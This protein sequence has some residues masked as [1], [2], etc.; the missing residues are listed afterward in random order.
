MKAINKSLTMLII[1]SIFFAI[2]IQS[3]SADMPVTIQAK[4]GE[5]IIS[6][7]A[8][9]TIYVDHVK[10]ISNVLTLTTGV[11]IIDI[12]W[13][14][15]GYDPS[16]LP[17]SRWVSASTTLQVETDNTITYVSG[18]PIEYDPTTQTLTF[19]L[20]IIPIGGENDYLFIGLIVALIIVAL[21]VIL[22]LTRHQNRKRRKR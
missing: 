16:P 15:L 9:C 13:D 10:Q 4:Y 17:Y 11:H 19:T 3:V 12:T 14:L 5:E 2:F 7:S 8:T 22:K 1:I 18:S 6:Y 20:N 21:V